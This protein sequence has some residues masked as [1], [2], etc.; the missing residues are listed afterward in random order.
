MIKNE[1][2][3][4]FAATMAVS[5]T[6]KYFLKLYSI[7]HFSL[8]HLKQTYLFSSGLPSTHT[9][10]LTASFLYFY[11]RLGST[12]PMVFIFFVFALLWLYEIYMQRKRYTAL[13]DLLDSL[14]IRELKHQE[15]LLF[16]DLSGHDFVDIAVGLIVGGGMYA[17]FYYL[18]VF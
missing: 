13:I 1:F 12:N 5:Q 10:I 4:L 6:I 14:K 2:F 15:V 11:H 18:G 7:K 17:L 9:A 3:A 8:G 16:K